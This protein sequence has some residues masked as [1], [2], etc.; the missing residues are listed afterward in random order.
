MDVASRGCVGLGGVVGDEAA[1]QASKQ[2]QGN[3]GRMARTREIR[4]E[5]AMQTTERANCGGKGRA[6]ELYGLGKERLRWAEQA[7]VDCSREQV[8]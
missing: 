6:T 3:D 2:L 5:G 1:G 4:G 8:V 7:W